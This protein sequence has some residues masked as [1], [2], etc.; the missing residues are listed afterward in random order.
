MRVH[1][2]PDMTMVKSTT[3]RPASASGRVGVVMGGTRRHS[4]GGGNLWLP[5]STARN[6]R[7]ARCERRK[8]WV[9]A[10]AGMTKGWGS[11]R[12]LRLAL[13]LERRGRFLVVGKL[14]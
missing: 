13:F 6:A 14:E 5:I 9:P 12:E 7:F 3:F 2:G 8:P 4:R 11:S 10:F 1:I